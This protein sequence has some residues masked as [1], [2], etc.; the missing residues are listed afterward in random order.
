[1]KQSKSY[2]LSPAT[3]RA[4][5]QAAKNFGMSES[6]YAERLLSTFSLRKTVHTIKREKRKN[7][8]E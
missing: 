6:E 5:K 2:A 3:I 1:L 7:E 4:V 8:K